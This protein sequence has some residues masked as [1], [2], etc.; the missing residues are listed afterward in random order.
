MHLRRRCMST[1]DLGEA[2]FIV[3]ETRPIVGDE[4]WTS[5]LSEASS[6]VLMSLQADAL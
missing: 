3:R 5:P 1:C 4:C 2:L 6:C